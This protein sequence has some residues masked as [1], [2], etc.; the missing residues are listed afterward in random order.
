M[1]SSAYFVPAADLLPYWPHDLLAPTD[2]PL[3]GPLSQRVGVTALDIDDWDGFL[4]VTGTLAVW[5]E[6]ELKL[7]LVD[8]LSLILG[9]TGGGLTQIP[10]ELRLGQEAKVGDVSGTVERALTL[11][12]KG[13][14]PPYELVLPE[15][16]VKLR[17]ARRYLRPMVPNVAGDPLSGFHEAPA[18][19]FTEFVVRGS[20]AVNTDTGVRVDGFDRVDLDYAQIGSTGVVIR[21][22]DVGLR[23]SD[24]QRPVDVD[25]EAADLPENFKGVFFREL[26]VYNLKAVWDQ[27][28]ASIELTNWSFGTGGVTG[29][30]AAV[31]ELA[32]DMT[33]RTFALRTMQLV[34]EQNVLVQALVQGAV[35]LEFWDDRVL[36]L[37]LGITNDPE[38]DFPASLGIMGAVSAEQ[39]PGSSPAQP[40]ELLGLGLTSGSTE[41]AHLGVSKLAVRSAP[42]QARADADELPLDTR[43]FDVL[44]DGRFQVMPATGVGETALGAEVREL[45]LQ[46]A[47]SFSLLLPGG[48]WVD[49]SEELLTKIAAFPVRISRIGLGEEGDETWIGLD[50]RV[51]LAGGAVGA[52]V[53]G[54]RVFFG[55]AAG[56]HL[57]FTGIELKIVREPSFSLYGFLTM[58]SGGDPNGIGD[59]GDRTFQ[60]GVALF[61]GG[62]AGITADGSVL[63][64]TKSGTKFWYVALDAGFG[65]GIPLGSTGVSLFG[66]AL[67][68]GNN[69]SPNRQLTGDHGDQ[70]NWYRDWYK[71]SPGPFSVLNSAKWRP[72]LDHWA[73]GAGISLGSSDGKAWNMKAFFGLLMPG[74]V[75][76]IEGRLK[77]FSTPEPH[78]GPPTS[79]LIRGLIVLDFDE[80]EFLLALEVDYKIP[81]SGLLM[82][83]HAEGEIFYKHARP[84]QWHV[85][86][87]WYEPISR[88]VRATALKL[89]NWDAYLIL[90]GEDLELAE[91]TFPGIAF[92]V[93]YRSGFDKRWKFG[94]LRVV[95]AAWFSADV[96][97]SINPVYVLGQVGMHG[98]LAVK[99]WGFGFELGLDVQLALEAPVGEHD[100]YFAGVI[101]VHIGLP[102]PVPDIDHD[103]PLEW[104]DTR[105]L[106]P[107][108][109]PLVSAAS[110]TPG[111]G[112]S[113]EA[114]FRREQPVT[115]P[116]PRLPMDGRV[117]ID[118]FRPMI[119]AWTPAP[120]PGDLARPDQVGE[121]WYRYMLA[122]VRVLVTPA[123]GGPSHLATEDLFGVWTLAAGDDEGSQATS[124]ILWGLSPYPAAGA[125]TWPGRVVRRT[126][127]E[128]FF[129]EHPGY[130]CGDGPE[131]RRC[132]AFDPYPPGPYDPEL[133]HQPD[134]SRPPVIFRAL[135]G[136]LEP[137]HAKHGEVMQVPI[138]VVAH[139]GTDPHKQC[140][141]FARTVAL[142]R[143]DQDGVALRPVVLIWGIEVELPPSRT[144][145]GLVDYPAEQYTL[146]VRARLGATVV[147]E[148]VTDQPEFKVGADAFDHVE[149][150]LEPRVPPRRL[151]FKGM[152]C[153]VELCWT[154]LAML[155]QIEE[156][157]A[158]QAA[159]G[160]V[161][162]S[163]TETGTGGG[164]AFGAHLVHEP[165]A[166][167]RIE[168]DVR[169]EQAGSADGPWTTAGTRTEV[170]DVVVDGAPAELAPYLHELVP[171]DGD[172]PVYAD[173]DL[174]VTY[175]RQYVEAMYT[176]AGDPLRAELYDAMGRL[177]EPV[178]VPG[179]TDQ[180]ALPPDVAIFVDRL[181]ES[182]CVGLD[183]ATIV[184]NDETV[185]RTRLATRT[186][187]EV[188]LRGGGHAEP[189]H[190]WAFTTSRWRSFAEHVADLRPAP[191]DVALPAA[192]NLAAVA[193]LLGA[194]GDRDAEDD[195]LRQALQQHLGQRLGTL[196]E[197]GDVTLLWASPDTLPAVRAVAVAS[198]EP[199]FTGRVL[200]RLLD[201]DGAAAPLGWLRGRDG[202]RALAVPLAGGAPVPLPAGDWRLEF[203]HR[204]TG[205][206]GLPDLSRQGSDADEVASWA[207]TVGAGPVAL[208]D[209]EA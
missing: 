80:D 142:G 71:P 91:R 113:S 68:L 89:F 42:D 82:D 197:R 180:P 5:E 41:L 99:A 66:A 166:T 17:V 190:R 183:P 16:D 182:G 129:S 124:L 177:V 132:A 100:L 147:D 193:A 96:A 174:R 58:T 203:R 24:A 107:P 165:G 134:P 1:T 154:S 15:L 123:G 204:L 95:A 19:V 51:A 117:V 78:T 18:E 158:T 118:F 121:V 192:A 32:P 36:W 199:L 136:D 85:A 160:I 144:A 3:I 207:F 86:I 52:S 64:G 138:E 111:Y 35:R 137:L 184:G 79:E 49:I 155:D 63:F 171:G 81:S 115:G 194:A 45:G 139:A 40:G 60:G 22:E 72:E 119:S 57:E 125:L 20:V 140:L 189:L 108:V 55:G 172:R 39:P 114:L 209:P 4:T 43:F 8:G 201:S 65:P 46:L 200:V 92:A 208:V 157:E 106:P 170:L 191:W 56:V 159:W 34:L 88:R 173:Y 74:P 162:E 153:L 28:P 109:D 84:K 23:L 187:Y 48:L 102:W 9:R 143:G 38:L 59:P 6:L 29:K 195:A 168:L 7:P 178:A 31:F 149:L 146:R 112:A 167:Y 93:G 87:G 47:P 26:S 104:G 13:Y 62:S 145:S 131:R 185:Y 148:Q 120:T 176:V 186:A 94:P 198:P 127:E 69:V 135:P 110:V 163:I 53:K 12:L 2:V 181:L 70:F 37:D 105:Q 150:L 175:N 67:M 205:V 11:F 50:A 156:D 116:A 14:L 122:D 206:P 27:L 133:R 54:L 75:I 196:P 25:P 126:W 152:P 130:P 21:A 98:E 188:R 179:R 103:I 101:K 44:L 90:A 202:T 161:L 83:V 76:I 77:L 73:F 30:A 61:I 10:F 141:R 33:G 164:G 169:S 128:I 97:L 151:D